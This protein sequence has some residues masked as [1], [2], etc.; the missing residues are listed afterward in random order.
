[1]SGY[2]FTPTPDK[3]PP[4]QPASSGGPPEPPPRPPKLTSRDVLEPGEPGKRIF[5]AAYIEVRDLAELLGVRPFKVVAE[6]LALRIFKHADEVIDFTTA[7]EV[8]KNFGFETER[9]F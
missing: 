6:V 4:T 8:A 7:A 9:L 3:V 5:V 1:M 2:E